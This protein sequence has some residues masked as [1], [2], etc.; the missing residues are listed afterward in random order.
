MVK[1]VLKHNKLSVRGAAF[2]KVCNVG[3][4]NMDYVYHVDH[5]VRPGET[6]GSLGMQVFPGGKGLNQSV[7]LARAGAQVLHAGKIGAEGKILRQILSDAGADVSL[8]HVGEGA[9]GHAII[10]VDQSGQNCILL[11]GGTNHQLD[12]EFINAALE[13][14]E[15]GDI[16]LLQNE[17]NNL[18]LLMELAHQK[19][20]RIAFNPSP[21]EE[22][23]LE[24]P[25]EY[26]T[27]FLLNEIEG[28]AI[29]GETDP[30]IIADGILRKYPGSKVVLTLGKDG[31][32]YA[33]ADDR[34]RQGIFKVPVADTTAAG[35]TFTGYFLAGIADDLPV[36]EN[37]RR[38]SLASSI[39]VS[40]KGAAPS[41]PLLNEVLSSNISE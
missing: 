3:S 8:I 17:V 1:E 31:V 19:G 23:L 37:L 14:C 2:V 29:S 12:S 16:L 25:L 20:M 5:F 40:R 18:G 22:S 15:T 32:F 36:R 26:V 24:L 27:Y 28:Q 34:V 21:F 30:E 33:D 35:D 11:Y 38:A 7:A 13:K 9:S 41:I 39:A 10:Q 6:I 4:L